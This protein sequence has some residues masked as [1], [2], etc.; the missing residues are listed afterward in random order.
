MFNT[1]LAGTFHSIAARILR[2]HME[3]LPDC[4]RD[5]N[6]TIND[7]S[8]CR[9]LLRTFLKEPLLDARVRRRWHPELVF[10]HLWLACPFLSLAFL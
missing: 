7:Q 3:Q 4:G 9:A 6:F 5:R 2:Q 1:R 8:D 10:A